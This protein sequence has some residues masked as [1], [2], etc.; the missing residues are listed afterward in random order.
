MATTTDTHKLL[1]DGDWIETGESVEVRSPYSG[2]VVGRIA[3][4]GAGEAE[5][6]PLRESLDRHF[7]RLAAQMS[8]GGHG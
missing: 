4:A 1:L 2:D 7:A 8:A 5:R 3:K 6:G